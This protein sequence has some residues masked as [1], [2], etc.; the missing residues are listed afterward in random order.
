MRV[1]V[2]AWV[3]FVGW[4]GGCVGAADGPVAAL[5]DPCADIVLVPSTNATDDERAS[6]AAAADMWAAVAGTEMQLAG[7]TADAT[8]ATAA[9]GAT[10]ATAAT[11]TAIPI[12]FASAPLAFLGAYEVARGDLVI[13]SDIPDEAASAITVAHELGHAFGLVHVAG[14][15]SVMNAGNT[16]IAP[17]ALDAADLAA[18]WGLCRR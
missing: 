7:G 5:A 2:G 1:D 3:G 9:T 4:L 14:R 18:R 8:A 13:N 16:T 11:A 15:D 10:A 6:I 17:N 12:R